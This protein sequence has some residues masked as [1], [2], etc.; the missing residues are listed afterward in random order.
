MIKIN[1]DKCEIKGTGV[2]LI[3]ELSSGIIQ[4]SFASAKQSNG[5]LTKKE[6]LEMTL[7]LVK[8]GCLHILDLEEGK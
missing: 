6:C 5:K 8:K 1:E 4:V 7:A 2:Q 3:A